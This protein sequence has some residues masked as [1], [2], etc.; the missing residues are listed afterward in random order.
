[1]LIINRG[2]DA[3]ILLTNLPVES[4]DDTQRVLRDYARKWECEKGIRFLK[5]VVSLE[6]IRS[7]SWTAIC[8]LVLLAVLVMLYLTW[9]IKQ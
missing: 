9:L 2:G 8:R 1:M 4:T 3:I 7:F 6:R 5:S